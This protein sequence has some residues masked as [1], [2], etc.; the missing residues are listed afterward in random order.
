MSSKKW[1][2][3]PV[4]IQMKTPIV[5]VEV[6]VM[7]FWFVYLEVIL[8]EGSFGGIDLPYTSEKGFSTDLWLNSSTVV[9]EKM[10]DRYLRGH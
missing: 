10:T 4:S 6:I 5:A 1:V 2:D 7:W 8:Y 3:Y 9:T